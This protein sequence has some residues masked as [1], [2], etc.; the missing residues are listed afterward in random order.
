MFARRNENLHAGNRMRA[1]AVRHRLGAD[2]TEIG[3][4]MRLG[5]V[6]RA[7]PFTRNHVWR[8]FGLL[9]IAAFHQNGRNSAV[10]QTRIHPK[11]HV[12][13]RHVFGERQ[14]NDM[15]HPLPAELFRR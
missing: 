10:S 15:R 2:Q 11:R 14:R 12:G 7:A 6:H 1:I 3:A 13:A 4:A 8:I 9:L 5:Q